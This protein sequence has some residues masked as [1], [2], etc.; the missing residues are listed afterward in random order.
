[1]TGRVLPPV[2]DKDAKRNFLI[3]YAERAGLGLEETM[4]VGDGAN[5]IPMLQTAGLG[6]GFQPKP[7][8]ADVIPNQIIHTDLTSLLYIQGYTAEDIAHAMSCHCNG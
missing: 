3:S 2:L 8:V 6:V 4:A 1:M 5:D 7:N